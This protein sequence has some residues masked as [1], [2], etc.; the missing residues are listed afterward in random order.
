MFP[1]TL[2]QPADTDRLPFAP[3]G[4]ALNIRIGHPFEIVDDPFQGMAGEEEAK[5]FLFKGEFFQ[6]RPFWDIRQFNVTRR[7]TALRPAPT[8]NRFI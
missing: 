1:V 5:G 3:V 7:Q 4:Q 2:N 8:A 6:F